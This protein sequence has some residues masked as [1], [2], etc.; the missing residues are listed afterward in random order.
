MAAGG[1][2]QPERNML[3]L[4]GIVNHLHQALRQALQVNFILNCGRQGLDRFSSIIFA[5]VEAPV[6]RCLQ[7]LLERAEHG[8]DDQGGYNDGK[9]R[10]FPSLTAENLLQ[11]HD[12][13]EINDTQ[14]SRQTGIDQRTADNNVDFVKPVAQ[15]GYPNR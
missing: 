4:D 2:A 13:S 7:A 8:C 5:A 14:P 3:G 12:T 10:F 9:L 15:H 1:L 6:D 11:L